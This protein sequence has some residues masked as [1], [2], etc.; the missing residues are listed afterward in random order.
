MASP[1]YFVSSIAKDYSE[2][3]TFYAKQLHFHTGTEHTIDGKRFDLEMH[4]VHQAVDNKD[5]LRTIVN[6]DLTV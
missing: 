4:I 3:D 6:D 5:D 2:V 1:N